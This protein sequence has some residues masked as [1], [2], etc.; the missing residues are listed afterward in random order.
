MLALV[1]RELSEAPACFLFD[2]CI[3]IVRYAALSCYFSAN[4]RIQPIKSYLKVIEISENLDADQNSVVKNINFLL[5]VSQGRSQAMISYNQIL[6]YYEKAHQEDCVNVLREMSF[7]GFFNS[8]DV[9][10][11]SSCIYIP[12][13]GRGGSIS[14]IIPNT[15]ID[16]KV[17]VGCVGKLGA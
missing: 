1:V 10:S 17:V 16:E 3:L 5:D 9:L 7:M 11:S 13:L 15:C 4:T 14:C 8:N 6:N 2:C 12:P